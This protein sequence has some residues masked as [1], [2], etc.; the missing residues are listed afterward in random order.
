[1]KSKYALKDL[2]SIWSAVTCIYLVLSSKRERNEILETKVYPLAHK[3]PLWKPLSS[4]FWRH[5]LQLKVEVKVWRRG[6]VVITTAQ[7][8]LTEPILRFCAGSNH[9]R[10]VSEIR[11]GEDAF[12]RST[13]PQ[14][15]SLL[16][17][18]SSS[19]SLSSSFSGKN[20]YFEFNS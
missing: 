10:G 13:M 2:V 15:N 6:V 18:S 8:H 11:D 17:S 12:R 3:K 1:M 5:Q 4:K 14:N 7:L 20:G 9:A 16:F 19:S